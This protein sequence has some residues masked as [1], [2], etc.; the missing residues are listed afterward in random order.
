M[1][2]LCLQANL[3]EFKFLDNLF[4]NFK[5]LTVSPDIQFLFYRTLR[6]LFSVCPLLSD[7]WKPPSLR[8]GSPL[9]GIDK[10]EKEAPLP[11]LYSSLCPPVPRFIRRLV[12]LE[13]TRQKNKCFILRIFR[14]FLFRVF[15]NL[16]RRFW[17]RL[18]QLFLTQS[19]ICRCNN[20]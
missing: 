14:G 9:G 6:Q 4:G 8:T 3:S 20:P 15:I 1:H 5:A 16:N 12:Q 11:C 18:K 7:T 17:F 13:N 19:K 10:R 2:K